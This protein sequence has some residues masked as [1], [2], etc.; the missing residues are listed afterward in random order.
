VGKVGKFGA[1]GSRTAPE[2]AGRDAPKTAEASEN[3]ARSAGSDAAV[4]RPL[5]RLGATASARF[6]GS[7]EERRFGSDGARAWGAADCRPANDASRPAAAGAPSPAPPFPAGGLHDVLISLRGAGPDRP[8][9]RLEDIP[10][11][12]QGASGASEREGPQAPGPDASP[13]LAGG[14]LPPR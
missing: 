3:A 8:A 4:A 1:E 7:P 9:N 10:D 2:G 13:R 11:Q 14:G 5:A 12:A 6:P